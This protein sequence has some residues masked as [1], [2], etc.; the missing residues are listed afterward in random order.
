MMPC[1]GGLAPNLSSR[2]DAGDYLVENDDQIVAVEGTLDVPEGRTRMSQ[3]EP[4][5]VRGDHGRCVF[6]ILGAARQ[7]FHRDDV[8]GARHRYVYIVDA[9]HDDAFQEEG[10]EPGP[11]QHQITRE[12][13][14]V[15]EQR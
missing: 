9:N 7:D 8:L 2:S 15:V 11:R 10:L 4:F 12:T 6:Q 5:T 14:R 13:C 1:R 3:I